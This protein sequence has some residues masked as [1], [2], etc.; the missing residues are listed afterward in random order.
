M[1]K[2]VF[3]F[4]LLFIKLGIEG[5]SQKSSFWLELGAGHALD[6]KD[7]YQKA[8]TP[9][10]K[11]LFRTGPFVGLHYE[12]KLNDKWSLPVG[13]LIEARTNVYRARTNLGETNN[14]ETHIYVNFPFGLNYHLSEKVVVGYSVSPGYFL[15]RGIRSNYTEVSFP[16]EF[17]FRSG[18]YYTGF[19]YNL[20]DLSNQIRVQFY[21]ITR[22]KL[23][24]AFQYGILPRR[25]K[26]ILQPLLGEGVPYN[27]H[28]QILQLSAGWRLNRA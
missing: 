7:Y 25:D 27:Y 9:S 17:K 3:I 22:L 6:N 19:G 23:Q 18:K 8:F 13:M 24:G 28:W 16:K 4:L 2:F 20:F 1:Q 26:K 21:P 10:A 11:Y 14:T 12:R 5:Y 15:Y